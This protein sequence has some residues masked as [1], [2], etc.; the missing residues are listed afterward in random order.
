MA[1]LTSSQYI[2][3]VFTDD[4]DP[5]FKGTD[6]KQVLAEG[7]IHIL[8]LIPAEPAGEHILC[9]T[10]DAF[11]LL[12]AINNRRSFQH[13]KQLHNQVRTARGPALSRIPV[14]L[15][16]S[17]AD[18][19]TERQ[20]SLEEGRQLAI[21]LRCQKLFEISAKTQQAEINDLFEKLVREVITMENSVPSKTNVSTMISPSPRPPLTAVSQ[22]PSSTSIK[23][24]EERMPPTTESPRR[25]SN[26]FERLK[27]GSLKRKSSLQSLTR[28]KSDSFS[29]MMGRNQSRDQLQSAPSD[30][31]PP[32]SSNMRS[33]SAGNVLDGTQSRPSAPLSRQSQQS[34]LS[35]P[36]RLDVDTSSWRE[37][38]KWPTEII[39][40]EDL[41]SNR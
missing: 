29:N 16:G 14:F 28:K 40:E 3:S 23:Q 19:D 4:Y 26:V 8:D 6:Q 9:Q 2:H 36:Y 37:S 30:N 34:T 15:V 7:L 21:E 17:K 24:S 33:V 13:I 5:S 41:K 27:F 35:S 12:Y 38:I 31:V 20:V 10:G 18:L 39:P 11:I 1:V 22:S 25:T 32:R